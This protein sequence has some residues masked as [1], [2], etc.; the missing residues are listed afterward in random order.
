MDLAICYKEMGRKKEAI[1]LLQD[2]VSGVESK[3]KV[4]ESTRK[5]AMR[6]VQE[7]LES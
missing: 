5:R 1:V 2:V 6:L 4:D 7:L 3:V